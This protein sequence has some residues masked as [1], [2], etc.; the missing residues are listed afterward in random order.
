MACLSRGGTLQK[1]TGDIT[2][3]Q[4]SFSLICTGL[5]EQDIQSFFSLSLYFAIL[6]VHLALSRSDQAVMQILFSE[7]QSGQTD[8]LEETK[9]FSDC[10]VGSLCTPDL[11]TSGLFFS[12]PRNAHFNGH[13]ASFT[14]QLPSRYLHHYWGK[15]CNQGRSCFSREQYYR[16][17]KQP[18]SISSLSCPH[19]SS[20][21]NLTDWRPLSWTQLEQNLVKSLKVSGDTGCT[22][23]HNFAGM[24]KCQNGPSHCPGIQRHSS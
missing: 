15:K 16:M 5:S 4:S 20:Q 13:Q 2:T 1:R 21:F 10:R 9:N 17:L 12:P 7:F 24:A 3:L 14:S 18:T 19:T 11:A 8:W 23:F 6:L 22:V